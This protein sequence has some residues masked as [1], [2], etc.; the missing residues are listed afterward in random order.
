MTLIGIFKF[1]PLDFSTYLITLKCQHC[2]LVIE[3]YYKSLTGKEFQ[4]ACP[5][6]MEIKNSCKILH[7]KKFF[8]YVRYTSC[9]QCLSRNC[10]AMIP[11]CLVQ[12][13]NC[14]PAHVVTYTTNIWD[15]E[16]LSLGA[17]VVEE[18]NF[19]W[20]GREYLGH[21]IF[22]RGKLA[23]LCTACSQVLW[24]LLVFT[25]KVAC[26]HECWQM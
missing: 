4:I 26:L 9:C 16:G 7:A 8:A 18:A 6:T 19:D 25:C 5:V 21:I 17:A 1:E 22:P 24:L 20:S 10:T 11:S 23:A 13:Q 3:L 2:T 15:Y 14:T 12:L